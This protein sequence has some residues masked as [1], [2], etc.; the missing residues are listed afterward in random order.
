VGLLHT[1]LKEFLELE[2]GNRSVFDYMRQFNSLAQYGS[3]HI[4]TDEKKANLYREGL[5]IHLQECLNLSLNLSDNELVSAAIGQERLMK[6]VA[7]AD[8]KKRKNMISRS[9]GSGSSS[10]APLKYRMV[11]TSPR[12]QLHRP[13]QQ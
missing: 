7:E 2:Q 9:T 5:T 13:Q 6:A 8:E 4:D 11:Y 10:G 3:Y 1:K 12:G